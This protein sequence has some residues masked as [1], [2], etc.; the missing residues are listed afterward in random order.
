MALT[1]A[2]SAHDVSLNTD[3]Y[4]FTMA[5]GYWDAGLVDMQSCFTVFFRSNPF[6]GGYAIACGMSQIAELVENFSFDDTTIDYLASLKAPAGGAMFKPG[7]LDYL[8]TF[9]MHVDIWAVP[10]GDV[11]F[12]REPIVRVQGPLID[13]QLLETALLN[14]VNFQTSVS[15]THLTLPTTERV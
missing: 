7:F 3:L 15:Y 2:T 9:R 4:E 5:Q 11:V 10:E 6:D 8:R 14:T 12:P 1:D 13:C